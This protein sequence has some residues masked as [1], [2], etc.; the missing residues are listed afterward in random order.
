MLG[1]FGLRE[2]RMFWLISSIAALQ[3]SFLVIYHRGEASKPQVLFQTW[4]NR[5]RK[6]VKCLI[7]F[8]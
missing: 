6:A 3:V 4:E 2:K 5:Y 7:L 1:W 8:M